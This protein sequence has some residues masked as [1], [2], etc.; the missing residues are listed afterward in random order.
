MRRI[1]IVTLMLTWIPLSDSGAVP[2]GY[3]T[4]TLPISDPPGTQSGVFTY[5]SEHNLYYGHAT[6]FNVRTGRGSSSEIWKYNSLSGVHSLFYSS[7]AVQAGDYGM[8]SIAGIWIDETTSPWTYYVADQEPLKGSPWTT[9][10]VWRARDLNGDG[11]IT[12][13]DDLIEM[14]TENISTLVYISDIIGNSVTNELYVTHSD[15]VAG[16]PMV[17]RLHDANATGYIEESEMFV[18]SLLPNDG[19]Y[20]GGLCFDEM[21]QIIFTH[22]TSG[23]IYRL[24]DLNADNDA[25]DPGET[26]VYAT[27]PISGGYDLARDPDGDLFVSASDWSTMTHALYE[28]QPGSPPQVTLFHDLTDTVGFCGKFVFGGDTP[29]EPFQD[30]DTVLYLNYSSTE[31]SDPTDFLVFYPL[32]S[33]AETPALTVTGI[34]FVLILLGLLLLR[35]KK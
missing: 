14:Y 30:G 33:S 29:F 10:G 3:T 28:I 9:G 26:V 31:W 15:G 32:Q 5:D 19:F 35:T 27:L 6:S 20:T 18:F 25:L 17:Y 13:D 4:G 2:P 23:A 34:I 8:N 16:N 1:L 22:D 24:E 21:M 12:D 7:P 11:A